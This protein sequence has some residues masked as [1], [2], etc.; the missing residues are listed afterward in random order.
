MHYI[1]YFRCR[2]ED[3]LH[4]PVKKRAGEFAV[5]PPG[6]PGDGGPYEIFEVFDGS[7][8]T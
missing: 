8:L 5:L 4:C 3:F 7:I 6:V 2:N 1:L